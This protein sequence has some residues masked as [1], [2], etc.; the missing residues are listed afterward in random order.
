MPKNLLWKYV[1]AFICFL[2][3]TN[4][5]AQWDV[6]TNFPTIN[7][8]IA[9]AP[10]GSTINVSP[11]VYNE[12][13]V[14]NKPITLQGTSEPGCL[15]DGSFLPAGSGISILN[16]V[17]NVTIRRFTIRSHVGVNPNSSAGI[18]GNL[19]NHNLLVEHCTIV[20]NPNCSGFYANGAVN[21]VKLDFLTVAG[22]G[23]GARGI[24]IW[25]GLKS[26][27][28]ITN[29]EV[30]GNNC[31]GIEL[32]DGTASAVTISNNDVHDNA[33]NGIGL[34][35]LT[36][37]V[38]PN[39]ISGNSVS[40][41]GRFGIEVK[42]PN[43]GTTLSG[44]IV[45]R[46]IP[47]GDNRDIAGIAVFR[48]GWV[49]GNNNVDIP[50]G[51]KVLGN[52]V[53]GYM[54]PSTSDGFGI[55]IEGTNHAV[56]G[57]LVSNCDV[58]IQ[59]QAGHLPYVANTN[60][61]GDQNNL[62]DAYFGR[63]NSPIACGNVISGNNFAGNTVN[64]RD[65]GSVGGSGFVTNIN[66]GETFCSIQVAVNDAQ[67][68]NGHTIEA[69]PGTYN[70][71]V[72]VNKS[73]VVRGV[74]LPKPVVTYTGIVAGKPTLFDVSVPAVTI[75]NFNMNV[76]LTRLSSAIIASGTNID[77]LTVKNNGITP[78]GTSNAASFGAYGNRNAISINYGGSINYRIG[79]A[80]VNNILVQG[81]TLSF[82]ADDGFGVTRAF[83]SAVSMDEGSGTFTNNTFQS[84]NHDVLTRFSNAGATNI[85]NNLFNGGG[86]EYAEPNAGAG[87]CLIIGNV[88]NAAFANVVA[89][90]TAV[91]RLKNNQVGRTVH[92]VGNKFNDHEWAISLENFRNGSVQN[93][94]FKP[95]LNS[96]TF[97]HVTVNT[98]SISTN[99]STI[100][101]TP[102]STFMLSN[103]FDGSGVP[104]G[105]AITFLNHD[106]DMAAFGPIDIHNNSFDLSLTWQIEIDNQA[107]PSNLSTFPNYTST[108]GAGAGAITLMAPWTAPINAECN[109]WGSASEA[110]FVPKIGTNVDHTPWL[111]NGTDNSPSTGFQPVPN[112]C[113]GGTHVHNITQG[114]HYV[115]IQQ[116]VNAANPGDVL[117]VDPGTYNENVSV[118]KSLTLRGANYGLSCS[119]MRNPE[120]VVVGGGA[121]GTSTITIAANNVTIDGFKITNTNGS[122]GI[123]ANSRSGLDVEHNIITDIGNATTG[124]GA[125]VGVYI[126][127]GSSANISSITISNNCINQVRGGANTG[128]IGNP[129]KTNNGSGQGVLVG[130]SNS[131]GV[132]SGVV[133]NSNVID[134]ITGSTAAFADGGKGAYGVQ[135]NIRGGGTG[136]VNAASIAS[137]EIHDL[138]GLWSHGV[139]L[140]GNTPGANVKNNAIHDLV[141]HKGNTDA[142]GVRLEDNTGS[143]TVS[144][145]NNS[146][147]N[148][149]LA[150]SNTTV[151]VVNGTCNWYG[152]VSAAAIAAQIQGPVTYIPWLNSGTD[153]SPATGFQPTGTCTGTP[154][155]LDGDGVP[156]VDDCAPTNPLIGGKPTF[157][158]NFNGT[159]VF[160][161]NN[162]S[163]DPSESAG[164]TVCDG[165][166]YTV[167]GHFHSSPNN[168]Y[169]VSV[170]ASGGTLLFN[171]GPAGN[172]VITAA[173][174]SGSAGSYTITL[175]DPNTGGTVIQT[176]TPFTDLNNNG[177]LDNTDCI[178]D[179]IV[180][181]YNAT[182]K[183]TW[184]QDSDGDS[185]GNPL[186]SQR[187]CTQPVGYVD[188]ITDCDDNNPNVY[189]GAPEV[190]D[191]VDNDCDGLVDEGFLDTDGDGIANCVD[192]D[193]DG[194]G[195]PDVTDCAPLNP[196]IGHTRPELC[197][198]IDD[199]CDGLVDEGFTDTDGDGIANC[200][201]TDD[202]GDGDPDVTDCAPLNPA[203]G[204]TRPE[205]CN[206]IDD[207]CDGLVDEGFLDTDGDGIA[208][209]VDTDD[210][211]DGDPD[212]TDCAP[213]NPAIGH[214]RPELCNGIDDDCDGLVDEGFTDT[215]G[216]G[217]ANC[218]DTDDDGDG[219][220]DVTDCAPLNPAIGHTRPEVCNG[221]DD[222]CDGLVDEGF[223]DTDG[224]GIAN[225]VDNDD[226]GD[227]VP[228]AYDCN[229]MSKKDDKWVVCHNGKALCIAQPAV[230]AHLAHGD[231]L[232]SCTSA[233]VINPT[234]VAVEETK[235]KSLVYPN[236]SS[237]L[238]TVQLGL[239]QSK[240]EVVI[241]N[242]N[243]TIIER[244]A[245]T[246]KNLNETFQFNLRNKAAGV[247]TVQIITEAGVQTSKIVIQK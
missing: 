160:N 96:T 6:P 187:S 89:P 116:A 208:N 131:T 47:I 148:M 14:I 11:G 133:I 197:N 26:N 92:A 50:T 226:D 204:H 155:D 207:D 90:N 53:S 221:I 213:L 201:D 82:T 170:S 218:M 107:G 78:T 68:V 114:T 4:L 231:Q 220:P 173:Q 19:S 210:D 181:K 178:G 48:R 189:L 162:G 59:Q 42:L 97:H 16:N 141:D 103:R 115:T 3:C 230:A 157:G 40:N 232:G 195:D 237:G 186:V 140:E 203:I 212:V 122:Y 156:N 28:T 177:V 174:F 159:P 41:N 182:P 86:V 52:N 243:G 24:V 188:D 118:S 85:T 94:E 190:C 179:P 87:Q 39:L 8:A 183:P 117:V 95:L 205:V 60:V 145:N 129:A 175:A 158:L 37:S 62:P 198:G 101:Q 30:F 222:D 57:N 246:A 136:N 102:V 217:I 166:Q 240:A 35:G 56:Q 125:S 104:G 1:L 63:G 74:G 137:N 151:P 43:G 215:D 194:D 165:G 75:E 67:T 34:T 196:A 239:S 119:G 154:A 123:S 172:A 135:L 76:D 44:N 163:A 79:G 109:W 20:N 149:P 69:S 216:D 128:L 139:G 245:V 235:V 7:A 91:L 219:D 10:P 228:D 236:P 70:E 18:N 244:R 49:A 12:K 146:F 126:D 130:S 144:I 81:N 55:V 98:K 241:M 51:V 134:H 65:V 31:C 211:G 132:A 36:G 25:N 169:D 99:S 152:T 121:S 225:C 77:N 106:A 127:A 58:G 110:A 214:T 64:T 88:F 184:Y 111:A 200:M 32:Q 15:I 84:I 46:S 223:P 192:T 105:S 73:L 108:I 54:Q 13:V 168:L 142:I 112:S 171:G 238:V 209:C 206:G 9:A 143:G 100:V 233:R 227:G 229:P 83:R 150:I 29:C 23:V 71:Q 2:K 66:T 113:S 147:T 120:S 17:Q 161:I 33:D 153:G 193:D 138:E 164:I 176:I 93:S 38:G 61:D 72:V 242:S 167:N 21:N 224:D 22:H 234:L 45:S 80:S 180:F 199:D 27:I 202:D 191:G 124:S 185:K 5:Y 247:Y